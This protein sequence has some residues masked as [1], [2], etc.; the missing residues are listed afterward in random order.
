[1][2]IIINKEIKHTRKI[3]CNDKFFVVKINVDNKY[4]IDAGWIEKEFI[5][6]D[7]IE[8][9]TYLKFNKIE[10]LNIIEFTDYEKY[11]KYKKENGM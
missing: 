3:D 4:R 8:K 9:F 2:N 5:K 1:M 6:E 11:K 10:I 7:F